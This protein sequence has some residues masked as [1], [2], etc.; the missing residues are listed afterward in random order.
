MKNTIFL[1]ILPFFFCCSLKKEQNFSEE[2]ATVKS[3]IDIE[4]VILHH[5]EFDISTSVEIPCGDFERAFVTIMKRDTI[6][7]HAQ[8]NL[9][10]SYL[11]KLTI[12]DSLAIKSMDT[13]AKLYFI[14]PSDTTEYCINSGIVYSNGVY[15]EISDELYNYIDNFEK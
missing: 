3:N 10:K 15:Y 5:V 13:R 11:D 8:I 7:D 4:K 14:S 6:M 1:F 12:I 9:L 2:I